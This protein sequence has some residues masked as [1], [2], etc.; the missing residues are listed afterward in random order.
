[1]RRLLS[2]FLVIVIALSLVIVPSTVSAAEAVNT[3]YTFR[4]STVFSNYMVLQQNQEATIWGY[5]AANAS[6][7]VQLIDDETATVLEEKWAVS[8]A[9][10]KWEVNFSPRE[11]SFKSYTI[12]AHSAGI[13]LSLLQVVFGEVW[14]LG[15]QSNMEWQLLN[16]NDAT[17]VQNQ[18]RNPYIRGYFFYSNDIARYAEILEPNGVWLTAETWDTTPYFSAIGYYFAEKIFAELNVPIGLI[19]T[20][21][22]GSRLTTWVGG[23]VLQND[24]QFKQ[25]LANAGITA[26]DSDW[27]S[28]SGFYNSKVAPFRGLHVKGMLWYQG[29]AEVLYG[30]QD[31][32][33]RH[34]LPLLNKCWSEVFECDE[35][36]L[37]MI[38]MQLARY[39]GYSGDNLPK[40]NEAL[41]LGVEQV[42]MELGG[43][44][45]AIPLYDVPEITTTPGADIHPQNK[46]PVAVRAA[47]AAMGMVYN[48]QGLYSGPVP[49]SAKLTST[50]TI[51][52]T[53]D[54]VGTGLSTLNS[55]ALKG[56]TITYGNN[57]TITP[58][59]S[60][61]TPNKVTLTYSNLANLGVTKVCYA[62][63]VDNT[64]SN[65]TNSAGF[66]AVA[67]R[68]D[69]TNA[70][71]T[72][73]SPQGGVY[74]EPIT[75]TLSTDSSATTYYT[76]DGSMP[77]TSSPIYTAPFVLKDDAT[78]RY[79]SVNSN[80]TEKTRL[81]KYTVNVADAVAPTTT[82]S[83]KGGVYYS[84]VSVKLTADEE[85]AIYYT[86]DGT[87]PSINSPVYTGEILI[88]GTA[89][90][91]FFAVD[92]YGNA[93]QVKTE[94]YVIL[95]GNAQGYGVDMQ[96]GGREARL[97]VSG[98]Y[99]SSY[100]IPLVVMLH[101]DGQS[102]KQFEKL[103]EMNVVADDKGFIVLYLNADN[104]N[105]LASW[106][107][108]ASS[109]D[110]QYIASAIESIKSQYN[111][112]ENKIYA[113]GFGAG[114]A[115]S[116]AVAVNTDLISGVAV[117]SGTQFGAA[118]NLNEA[119]TA[120]ALGGTN[121]GGK[122]VNN[123]VKKSVVPV[124]V[125]HGENDNVFAPIN[126][127]LT[128]SQWASANDVFDNSK[129][130]DSIYNVPSS[131]VS[132]NG[133]TRYVYN[134]TND[135]TVI[136]K[137]IIS[138][139]GYAWAGTN[140][141]GAYSYQSAVNQS[142][143]IYDFFL[144][145]AELDYTKP[146]P[147][148]DLT[149]PTT[150]P[151]APSGSY[152]ESVSVMLSTNE[153]ATTY[154]TVDGTEPTTSSSVYTLPLTFTSNTVLKF[155]SVDANGN[156]EQT[157]TCTYT[158]TERKERTYT[159]NYDAT[160]S[161]YVSSLPSIF[162]AGTTMQAGLGGYYQGDS[163]R[164]IISFDTSAFADNNITSVVL[165]LNVSACGAAVTAV[166]IDIKSG[167]FGNLGLENTD[168]N[169]AASVS[170]IASKPAVASGYIDLEIPST[171]FSYIGNRVEFRVFATV[172]NG[173]SLSTIT[174]S[175]AQL[176]VTTN[177]SAAQTFF[178]SRSAYALSENIA[179][180]SSALENAIISSGV[181]A[182]GD[183]E[184]SRTEILDLY[185]LDASNLAISSLA[186]LEYATNLRYLDVSGNSLS[187]IS[188]I[189]SLTDLQYLNISKNSVS[190][191]TC[192][193]A[194]DNLLIFDASD[195]E[196]T[197]V[198][199][200]AS[201]ITNLYLGTNKITDISSL[202]SLSALSVA[203]FSDNEATSLKPL[204]SLSYLFSVN[205]DK[206]KLDLAQGGE[207]EAIVSSLTA[208]GTLVSVLDQ[209]STEPEFVGI[210][211]VTSVVEDG[212]VI[213]TVKTSA[214][215]NRIKVTTAD[216]L[217]NYI[218]YQ[219]KCVVDSDGLCVYT[220]TVPAVEGKTTY[221]FDGRLLSTG[222][223]AADYYY[224]DVTVEKAEGTIKSVAYEID[225]GKI[226]FTVT[227]KAG[228]FNRIKV[229]TA[230]N[231]TGSLGVA[232]TYK[233]NEDGDYVWTIKATAP[234]SKTNYAFDLR[235]GETGK[236]LKE[237]FYFDA[238]PVS[239]ETKT[240]VKSAS[241]EIES[242]KIIFTVVTEAGAYS[243]IKVTSAD[244]LGGSLGV[245]NTYTVNAD[246][247]YVWTVKAPAPTSKTT[248]ALDLRNAET[249]K[250]LKQYFTFE[251]NPTTPEST[252]PV[253][254]VDYTL[255]GDKLVF[256]VVTRAGDYSRIKVTTADNLGGSLKVAVD[257]TVNANGDYVWT[258]KISAPTETTS[259]AFDLRNAETG[260]Y[261]KDYFIFDVVL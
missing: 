199:T 9:N 233:V 60:I 141:K 34:G 230:N 259:Y 41:A 164:A 132:G 15:G 99:N 112:D 102:A 45:I 29:E 56:F 157:Q 23:D 22:G 143:L 261:L 74:V 47:N 151:S 215:F 73:V 107:W 12:S 100:K 137:Y 94:S 122:I 108:Y 160:N 202:S 88:S 110:V 179:F 3:N 85:A 2:V 200:L 231:L 177:K 138:S 37:P 235:N 189:S 118:S 79:F 161:G 243:R 40:G 136:E 222:K 51:E 130:D 39:D 28:L 11:G 54:N 201:S 14:V 53:F 24:A 17:T 91:K 176:I 104:S 35:A 154:Y 218:S 253:K 148:R 185:A 27:D 96:L 147:E 242:D 159:Y 69:L 153:N 203:D 92:S 80:G 245:A 162:G 89:D 170:A 250:Y 68:L 169:A 134:N 63:A 209:K 65:L 140:Y 36:L 156:A 16:T 18:P 121:D 146:A 182:N 109:N 232:N 194:F 254:S 216:S 71:T 224:Y 187:D 142:E 106:K 59:M 116:N 221:A 95:N 66:P 165:R 236:Y 258:M 255:S 25:I 38:T 70:P 210:K 131:T 228:E 128:V 240:P 113:V 26:N 6:V 190:D 246:G 168:F 75:V 125:I 239:D 44:A 192:L 86:L 83:V 58:T 76:L 87:T 249:G 31:T 67:F 256:T 193:S 123:S 251:A 98:K 183:N 52:V 127:D 219:S 77:T 49:L 172:T 207:N 195:N 220:L 180:E 48:K 62:F 32:V 225:G 78:V 90:L 150:T 119:F 93:E 105:T 1:M 204:L 188:K 120:M 61:T 111:I 57:S 126:A 19:H 4:F 55:A 139:M 206:N 101:G 223:Y 8:D 181:D 114:A 50:N 33:L 97:Y 163:V 152:E 198:P 20:A 167:A 81:V 82:A 212:K 226:I 115:M 229:T 213:F 257:Y 46:K 196:I 117:A 13:T 241:Y 186:G 252:T 149:A 247:D 184:I 205:A 178:L 155:F 64:A 214:H 174:F 10:G 248:Y 260:K 145:T 191:I 42:N 84:A 234:T 5:G 135:Y 171:C 238:E 227:T 211:S 217:K 72:S 133:Y 21:I 103:T 237:Y 124:I 43:N 175:Q 158:I 30:T 197:S 144:R 244:N 7:L 208:K 173:I 129:D 166:G